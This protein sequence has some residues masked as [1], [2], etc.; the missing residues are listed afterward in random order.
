MTASLGDI[1]ARSKV[2]DDS[3]DFR[4]ASFNAGGIKSGLLADLFGS[5]A[6]TAQHGNFQ[7][8][9]LDLTKFHARADFPSGAKFLTGATRLMQDFLNSQQPTIETLQAV[10]PDGFLSLQQQVLASID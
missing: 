3:L 2:G 6:F 10:C 5:V 7:R 4:G 9:F 1:A 8:L